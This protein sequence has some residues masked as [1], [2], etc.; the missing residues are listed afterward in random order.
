MDEWVDER[1]RQHDS[2]LPPGGGER[3]LRSAARATSPYGSGGGRGADPLR[4]TPH[5]LP[6]KA[7]DAVYASPHE[8][9][10]DAVGIDFYDPMSARH[11]RVPGH[12]TGW[13]FDDGSSVTS[14]VARPDRAV[15]DDR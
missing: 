2:L 6:R 10:L 8:R 15:S 3:V 4:R 13:R 5:A 11:F 12:R 1:R 7:L 14:S 9:S